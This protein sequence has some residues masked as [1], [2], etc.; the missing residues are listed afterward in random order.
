M[1]ETAAPLHH[2]LANGPA[3]GKAYWLHTEDGVRLRVAHWPAAGARGTVLLFP[4]RTEYIEKYG[5]TAAALSVRGYATLVIDW[6][7]QG[8]AD[9]PLRDRA[10]GHVRDFAE[11]QCDVRALQD[12]ALQMD[13]PRPLFLLSH[14]MGGCIALRALHDGLP[15]HAAAFSAPMWGIKIA[16]ALRPLATALAHLS[17]TTRQDHRYVP[18]TGPKNYVTEFPFADNMLTTDPA[19]WNW[20]RS[21]LIA[22]PDLALG[23][24]SLGWLHHALT[25]CRALAALPS[26]DLP[27][28]TAM[29]TAER[30][31]EQTAIRAR[32]ARWPQGKLDLYPSA[33]HEVMMETPQHRDRFHTSVCDFYDANA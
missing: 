19:M 2:D 12:L 28:L 32:M 11:Y 13:M 21:H 9:R 31:V 5:P 1:I 4:G 23:G 14:S 6:R 27:T 25:E 17:R 16:P 22:Q 15:V 7:G 3:G 29:G 24:P 18:G 26:P 30:V 33:E 10:V 20:M 8:L